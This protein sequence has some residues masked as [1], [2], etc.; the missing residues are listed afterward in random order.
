MNEGSLYC[1]IRIISP[2]AIYQTLP[3]NRVGLQLYV[4]AY[5]RITIYKRP[6]PIYKNFKLER[7]GLIIQNRLIIRTIR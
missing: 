5:I 6:I 2:W 1:I 4:R 3:L 7:G